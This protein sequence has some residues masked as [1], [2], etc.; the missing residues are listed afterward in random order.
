M[1]VNNDKTVKQ[2]M[3]YFWNLLHAYTNSKPMIIITQIDY[4]AIKALLKMMQVIASNIVV[5][6]HTF[7]AFK[8]NCKS[9]ALSIF[10]ELGI[11]ASLIQ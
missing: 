1:F 6:L 9:Y 4:C 8:K 5:L 7:F 10:A 3:N 11:V 2:Q